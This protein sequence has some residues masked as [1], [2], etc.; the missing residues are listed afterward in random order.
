MPDED[1]LEDV[2]TRF[3][4]RCENILA[5]EEAK[6]GTVRCP[7][8]GRDGRETVIRSNMVEREEEVIECPEC[9]WKTTWGA[10]RRRFTRRQ[11]NIGAAEEVLRDFLARWKQAKT[12]GEK[13]IAVDQVIHEFHV[14]LMRSRATGERK[15]VPARAVAVNLIDGKLTDVVAF[16]ETLAGGRNL[17]EL[18]DSLTAWQERIK[19]SRNH[20]WKGWKIAGKAP[21][22]K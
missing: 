18:R 9:G 10:Y 21:R 1:L 15:T 8:C 2:G 4:M 3:T 12:A 5:V 20:V 11:L 13:M 22:E 19:A 14:Y 6:G 17:P 7:R 16:L